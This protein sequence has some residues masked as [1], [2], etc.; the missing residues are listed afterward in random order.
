MTQ[1]KTGNPWDFGMKAHIG[2]DARSGLVHTAGAATGSVHY[3]RVMDNLVRDDD[4]E[5]FADK[6]HDGARLHP[7]Q[8]NHGRKAADRPGL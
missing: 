2:V 1:S 3:A 8:D 6:G 5:V 7:C 4:R